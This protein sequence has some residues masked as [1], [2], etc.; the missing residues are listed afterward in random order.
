LDCDCFTGEEQDMPQL[1]E[2]VVDES[3][4]SSTRLR[5]LYLEVELLTDEPLQDSS[6]RLERRSDILGELP[7]EPG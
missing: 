4:V 1:L 6:K 7:G 3:D 2:Y 5:R